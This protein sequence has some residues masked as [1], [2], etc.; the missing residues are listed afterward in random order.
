MEAEYHIPIDECIK[1]EMS[2]MCNL[3]QGILELGEERGKAE[4]KAEIIIRMYEKGYP[5]EQIADISEKDIDEVKAII[6]SREPV[7][8]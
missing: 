6:E 4:G 2:V 1:K 7:P 8:V 5:L 3:G